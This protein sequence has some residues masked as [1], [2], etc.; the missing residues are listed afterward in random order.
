MEGVFLSIAYV[1]FNC[2]ILPTI[3]GEQDGGHP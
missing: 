3:E 1:V 2:Y